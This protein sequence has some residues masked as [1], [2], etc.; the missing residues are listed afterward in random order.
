MKSSNEAMA[1]EIRHNRSAFLGTHDINPDDT[2][3]VRLEYTG[4]DYRRYQTIGDDA[5]G[6]GIV[7][8]S[9]VVADA[10]VV[11]NPG[12]ALLLPLA[13]CIGA[14]LH[15]P[16]RDILMVSHL[17][18]HNL[19][20]H[21]GTASV[22]YLAKYLKV[23]PTNLTV[24]L[25]PAAGQTNYPLYAFDNRSLHDVAVEQLVAAGVL[26][27]NITVSSIDSSIDQNYYSHS[28]FLKGKRPTDGRF[29]IVAVLRD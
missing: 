1:D 7:R 8:P 16:A 14:V 22:G 18:R 21:G 29:A 19:E 12:H 17:G 24:W 15:D 23:D 5:K 25:S 4:A 10:L 2:T 13:D 9:S 11:T 3:L 28:Q 27:A 6:D 20:Q 26:R